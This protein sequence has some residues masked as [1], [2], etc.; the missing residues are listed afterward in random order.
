MKII[1]NKDGKI[2][3]KEQREPLEWILLI[4]MF[5]IIII[6]IFAAY[7]TPLDVSLF[8][9]RG[10]NNCEFRKQF[11]LNNSQKVQIDLSTIT[12]AE[13]RSY[14]TEKRGLSYH[15]YL[16]TKTKSFSVANGNN[17][18]QAKNAVIEF[19][20]FLSN[21]EKK[22]YYLRDGNIS[23]SFILM[24]M[25]VI[26]PLMYMF[27]FASRYINSVEIDKKE[28]KMLKTTA[29]FF[30]KRTKEY[31]LDGI[32]KVKLS[33]R[34]EKEKKKYTRLELAK[35]NDETIA[36][37][38]LYTAGEMKNKELAKAELERFLELN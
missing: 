37:T 7:F 24:I 34:N 5:I 3:L 31:S 32:T 22:I 20:N 33:K 18:D 23:G 35:P 6:F 19:N 38:E 28:N 25:F 9:D 13:L 10:L 2:I 15:V 17:I 1:S 21:P 16:I 26:I 11:F 29:S 4:L 30:K 12:G 8:C 27:K 14:R 36:L